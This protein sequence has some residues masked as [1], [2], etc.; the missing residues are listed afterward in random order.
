MLLLG[1]VLTT[2]ISSSAMS[3]TFIPPSMPDETGL[4]LMLRAARQS[5]YKT[6]TQFIRSASPD[7]EL[8]TS[9]TAQAQLNLLIRWFCFVGDFPA[10]EV[11]SRYSN[12]P[13]YT[14]FSSGEIRLSLIRGPKDTSALD[15]DVEFRLSPLGTRSR[16]L[17]HCTKC[18]EEAYNEY[19]ST[20][21]HRAHQLPAVE[22]CWKHGCSLLLHKFRRTTLDLPDTSTDKTSVDLRGSDR[23]S[24]A[25]LMREIASEN[26][27]W[28]PPQSWSSFYRRRLAQ[29][30]N[31]EV[32]CPHR[33][34]LIS[35]LSQDSIHSLFFPVRKRVQED[36]ETNVRLIG[37][38][39]PNVEEFSQSFRNAA[40]IE[41]GY[42][43]YSM[44]GIKFVEE[45]K[46][47]EATFGFSSSAKC[48]FRIGQKDKH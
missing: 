2:S 11:I 1:P 19:G 37:M 12:F 44:P 7:L 14:P 32:S 8:P 36:P 16:V 6:F 34:T 41:R 5:G 33:S 15:S 17:R 48:L 38:L 3:T 47:N 45:V 28:M 43:T 4:G 46:H 13:A 31:G 29:I 27:P 35:R 30:E 21:W 39:F 26:L 25:K 10:D 9:N 40:E 23:H 22:A 42:S 20:T 24:Y 18:D